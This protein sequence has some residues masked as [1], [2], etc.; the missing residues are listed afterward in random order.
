METYIDS[1][2]IAVQWHGIAYSTRNFQHE[3][4]V[5]LWTHQETPIP[6]PD[7]WAM[8]PS[9]VMWSKVTVRYREHTV[10]GC[11][12]HWLSNTPNFSDQGFSWRHKHA[13]YPGQVNIYPITINT[14]GWNNR[15]EHF[16]SSEAYIR[17]K[18]ATH[19]QERYRESV[20]SKAMTSSQMTIKRLKRKIPQIYRGRHKHYSK[21]TRLIFM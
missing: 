18:P 17:T 4:S 7:G 19:T 11:F 1:G 3:T 2:Y 5:A 6:R 15:I 14:L 13:D 16:V 12:N 9:W 8:S 10:V 21:L 20:S